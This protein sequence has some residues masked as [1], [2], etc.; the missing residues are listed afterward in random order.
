[1]A[2]DPEYSVA[3][4]ALAINTGP[5]VSMFNDKLS[6]KYI[7]TEHTYTTRPQLWQS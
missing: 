1:M 2:E 7:Y 4:L 5:F 6:H 3:P